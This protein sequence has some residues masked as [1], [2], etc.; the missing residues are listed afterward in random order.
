M[1]IHRSVT[2][3]IFH[4]I[5]FSIRIWERQLAEQKKLE[6]QAQK[7]AQATQSKAHDGRTLIYFLASSLDIVV[8]YV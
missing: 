2:M 5:V 1:R 3:S 7:G 4:S 8:D 6:D